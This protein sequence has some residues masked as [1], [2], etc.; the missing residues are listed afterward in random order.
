MI[1]LSNIL[2]DIDR[3]HAIPADFGKTIKLIPK[4]GTVIEVDV[5]P[6]ITFVSNDS[7]TMF[8]FFYTFF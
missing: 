3:V 1:S 5:A 2:L 4:A 6:L 8:R 7:K